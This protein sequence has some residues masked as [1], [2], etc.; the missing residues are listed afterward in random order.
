[1][2]R[3][4]QYSLVMIVL[5]VTI[6]LMILAFY[7]NTWA[8]I[9]DQRSAFLLTKV[10]I[11]DIGKF[12]AQLV[13]DYI[14]NEYRFSILLYP[15]FIPYDQFVDIDISIING[16]K[17]ETESY[18]VLMTSDPWTANIQLSDPA[19]EFLYK[20][21]NTNNKVLVEFILHFSP[22][23]YIVVFK[24]NRTKNTIQNIK[25]FKGE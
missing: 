12:N 16:K 17:I 22:I 14:G 11:S 13:M 15:H 1:M 19:N 20:N 5:N 18:K 21:L 10:K 25:N 2:N 7:S 23:D 3:K 4:K 9:E 6:I 8:Y 24:A